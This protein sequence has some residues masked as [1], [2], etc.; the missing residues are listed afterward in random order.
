MWICRAALA[1]R[2]EE[3][4][5]RQVVR[6][7]P[8]ASITGAEPF[9]GPFISDV[10]H[11]FIVSVILAGIARNQTGPDVDGNAADQVLVFRQGRLIAGKKFGALP[12][13][14]LVG[15]LGP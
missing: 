7:Q 12:A 8:V 13:A 10:Q 4:I 14:A 6:F 3:G 11:L 1:V 5:A 15:R 2:S 9:F